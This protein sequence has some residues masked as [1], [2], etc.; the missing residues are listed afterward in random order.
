M[1]NIKKPYLLFLGNAQNELDAKTASG[2]ASFCPDEVVGYLKLAQANF[3]LEKYPELSLTAAKEQGAQT[4]VIGVANSG[5]YIAAEWLDTILQAI[6]LGFDIASGMHS[7]LE[8]EPQIAA[9]AQKYQVKLHNVR[10]FSGELKTATGAPKLGTKIL[11]VGT[12]CSSG[13]MYSSLKITDALNKIGKKT[14]FIATGQTGIL[15]AGSGIAVDAVPADFISGSI[16]NLL[17]NQADMFDIIEG[18]GSLYHPSF[19][20]VSL[21]L[22][23]G[24]QAD[25][26]IMCHD[27]TRPHI[28]HLPDYPLADLQEAIELNLQ[29]GRLTNP[30]IKIAGICINSSKMPKTEWEIYRNKIIE[31][32]GLPVCDPALDDV[33]EIINKICA[34]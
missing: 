12:D 8:A 28:R 25:Y 5:G 24:A 30:Q 9:A 33:T 14:N 18:Q 3:R 26:L 4:L 10:H 22:L 17:S 34:N 29:L 13:K 16:E 7:K 19:A 27:P 32:T 1:L 15:I 23:H 20:G 21:G 31:K 11:T 2:I 6:E